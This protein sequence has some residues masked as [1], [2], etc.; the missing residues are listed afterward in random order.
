MVFYLT[1]YFFDPIWLN[2]T[3]E[4]FAKLEF[5]DWIF[6]LPLYS[7][8]SIYLAYLSFR[9]IETP[10]L[11]LKEKLFANKSLPATV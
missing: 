3:F 2:I 8:I 6:K 11:K 5:H 9:L 1:P 10:I 7:I 4:I